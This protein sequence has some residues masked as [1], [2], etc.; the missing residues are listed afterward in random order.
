MRPAGLAD[1][2]ADVAPRAGAVPWLD[3]PWLLKL[4]GGLCLLTLWQAVGSAVAPGL[5]MTPGRVLATLPAI[6]TGAEFWQAAGSTLGAVALGLA[7]ALP[8]GAGLGIPLGRSR[9][10]ELLLL[11]YVVALDALPAIAI[12]PLLLL[13]L[14]QGGV[15][16]LAAILVAAVIPIALGL[17]DGLRA[18]PPGYLEVARA[19]RARSRDLWLGVRLPALRPRLGEALRRAA[20]RALIAAIAAEL[21]IGRDGLGG[22]IMTQATAGRL[23]AAMTG[24]LALAAIGGLLDALLR[25]VMSRRRI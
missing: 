1:P 21:M 23:D 4:L 10:V 25:W 7:L 5:G 11:R 12:L 6:L 3:R 22:F 20:A 13:W 24:L 15:A 17:R 18:L 8:L 2:P 16:R 14:G 9:A 19:F